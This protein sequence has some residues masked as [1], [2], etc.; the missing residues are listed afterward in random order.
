MVDELKIEIDKIAAEYFAKQEL[1]KQQ[2][3]IE[4]QQA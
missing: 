2:K 3:E 1:E 4:A